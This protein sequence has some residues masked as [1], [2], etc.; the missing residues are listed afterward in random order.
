MKLEVSCSK[1][2]RDLAAWDL[3]FRCH[4]PREKFSDT[5]A[6]RPTKKLATPNPVRGVAL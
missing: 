2:A 1:L 4:Q 5:V 6:G 3:E